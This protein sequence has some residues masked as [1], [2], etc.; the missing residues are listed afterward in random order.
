MFGE[1]RVAGMI[2]R[3]PY[4]QRI[5]IWGCFIDF[6]GQDSIAREKVDISARRQ[7]KYTG[8]VI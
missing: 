2:L 5:M 4:T 6:I 3:T 7:P 1:K 8:R